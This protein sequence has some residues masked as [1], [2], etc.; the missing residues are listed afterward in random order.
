LLCPTIA[1]RGRVSN[2]QD[3]HHLRTRQQLAHGAWSMEIPA[4]PPVSGACE[5]ASPRRRHAKGTQNQNIIS[6][7][8]PTPSLVSNYRNSS[9]HGQRPLCTWFNLFQTQTKILY[10]VVFLLLTIANTTCKRF[11]KQMYHK[12][13]CEAIHVFLVF[14]KKI[15]H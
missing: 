13:L 8:S 5:W 11:G 2:V 9:H 7:S 15:F 12:N 4:G 10:I 3:A 1:G 14:F 6:L